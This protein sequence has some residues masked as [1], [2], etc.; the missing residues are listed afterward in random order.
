MKEFLSRLW[1]NIQLWMAIAADWIAQNAELVYEYVTDLI[2][3]FAVY[4]GWMAKEEIVGEQ[5]SVA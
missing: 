5:V 1:I 2:Q 3:T 4:M